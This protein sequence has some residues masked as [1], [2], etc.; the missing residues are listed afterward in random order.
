MILA[1]LLLAAAASTAPPL[2]RIEL[3]G[4]RTVWSAGKPQPNGSLLLF[5]HYPDGALMSVRKSDVRGVSE[6][7]AA[8]VAGG[9]KPGEQR[10]LGATGAGRRDAGRAAAA[11]AP[12]AAAR[13][14]DLRP[15]EGK[16]GTALFNPDR[17]YRPDWDGKL[18]PGATMPL[19]NSPNDYKEGVTLAHPA[20]PAVQAA[21]GDVPKAPN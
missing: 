2:Y 9:L 13:S 19:P 14:G 15:G 1:P 4:K 21:P 16:G 20:A 7:P 18:V 3:S 6:V 5:R 11:G 12:A 17:T 10:E 8:A